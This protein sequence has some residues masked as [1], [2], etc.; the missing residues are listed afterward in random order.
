MFFE[1]KDSSDLKSRAHRL[2]IRSCQNL[3]LSVLRSLTTSIAICATSY[4]QIELC[5]AAVST[6]P[7]AVRALTVNK[8]QDEISWAVAVDHTAGHDALR[9][10]Q[11][12]HGRWSKS[13][14]G[15]AGVISGLRTSP[16]LAFD[17]IANGERE[18]RCIDGNYEP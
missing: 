5:A 14:V 15:A 3:Q 17:N 18:R 6:A 10:R 11:T 16:M 13:G 1:V 2:E 9:S 4:F 8:R 12:V 7:M